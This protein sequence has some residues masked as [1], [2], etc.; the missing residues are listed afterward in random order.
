MISIFYVVVQLFVHCSGTIGSNNALASSALVHDKFKKSAAIIAEAKNLMP[1]GVNSPVRA[2]SSVGGDP[3][4]FDRVKG[5]HIHDVDGNEYIDYVNSWGTGIVGHAHP[6]VVDTIQKT[7]LKGTSFG[8]PGVL[9]NELSKSVLKAFPSMDMVRFTSSGTEAC[10]GALRVARA[11]TGRNKIVKF[12]GCYHG[13]A[14]SFLVKAG[15]GVAT[16]GYPDSPGVPLGSTTDTLTAE[17]NDIDSVKKLFNKYKGQIAAVIIEPVVGNA[18][19]LTP[20]KGFLEDLRALTT[21]EKSLLIFDEVMTGFRVS[22]GGAQDHF[23]IVPDITTLG[24]VIGGGMPVGAYGG[25]RDIMSMVAPAGPVYQAGTLSG[26]PLSMASGIKTLEILRRY[27]ART[28]HKKGVAVP[29]LKHQSTMPAD[30]YRYLQFL[31]NKLVEGL[32]LKFKQNYRGKKKMSIQ[33][34]AINGMFGYF[35]NSAPVHNFTDAKR[36]DSAMFKKFHREMLLRGVYLPPSSYEACFM[37]F[38][39]T[40]KDIDRTIEIAGEVFKLL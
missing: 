40:P 9:E 34:A 1:G 27:G 23:N 31:S 15:S 33:G 26:N 5:A 18:G 22:F 30:P 37:S 21:N 20:K 36:S 19:F 8:A 11:Y 12:N 17:Y 10:M 13:H 35:F 4:V 24:K 32:K 39:H 38:A 28:Y 14:D 16:L 3:I 25:R 7:V 6:E 2:F 29:P